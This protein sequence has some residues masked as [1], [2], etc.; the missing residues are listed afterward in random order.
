MKNHTL[1]VFLIC[2]LCASCN[3]LVSGDVLQN[4]NDLTKK[5]HYNRQMKDKGFSLQINGDC[6]D[7]LEDTLHERSVV[8][9]DTQTV[10][11]TSKIIDFKYKEACCQ[12]YL[13]DYQI[14]N[15]TLTFE[16][17]NVNDAVCSCICWY[18]YRLDLTNI[19]EN[20]SEI[21]INVR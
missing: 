8:Y 17:E 13:G 10:S 4:E 16:L 15:D 19:Q 7:A 20:Y 12:E 9:M 2:L 1:Q 6:D 3:E 5:E 14:N 18:R 21:K 11:S